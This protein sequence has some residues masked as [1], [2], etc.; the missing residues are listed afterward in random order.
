MLCKIV[1]VWCKT[2][3]LP[4]NICTAYTVPCCRIALF[5]IT[6]QTSVVDTTRAATACTASC[7]ANHDRCG[8]GD[9][10]S[11][12]SK[13]GPS[14]RQCNA[15]VGRPTKKE[16]LRADGLSAAKSVLS[17][18]CPRLCR[19]RC[20]GLHMGLD[21]Q[22]AKPAKAA[23]IAASVHSLR[24]RLRFDA[25]GSTLKDALVR[26]MARL[27]CTHAEWPPIEHFPWA[28]GGRPVCEWCFAAAAHMIMRPSQPGR[29]ELRLKA[30]MAAA[31]KLYKKPVGTEVKHVLSSLGVEGGESMVFASIAAD[32][33]KRISH[34]EEHAE[35]WLKAFSHEAAGNVQQRTDDEHDH[36]QGLTRHDIWLRY[37]AEHPSGAQ[38][39]TFYRALKAARADGLCDLSFHSWCAQAECACCTALKICKGRA[40]SDSEKDYWQ[41]QLDLHNFIARQERLCYGSNISLGRMLPFGL[42]C[43]SFALD[44]Y[45]T[46]KS[47]GPS[48]H[49]KPLCDLKG[50]PGLSGAEQLKFKTTGVIVHGFGYFLHV[51]EPHLPSNAN[52]NIYC[53][54]KTIMHMIGRCKDPSDD[55]VQMWP[56]MITVQVDGAS[57]NKCRAMFAYLEWLVLIGTFDCIHVS[58]LLVGHTHADYDQKF[59][60]LTRA[61]RLGEVK[62]MEDLLETFRC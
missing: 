10:G 57:D 30:S 19:V 52:S 24:E 7:N 34:K 2:V 51:L 22:A 33:T 21:E 49:A 23:A 9:T 31:K 37:H 17:F 3:P 55:R 6:P 20:E 15:H 35:C 8:A 14:S 28:V 56:R 53:L 13:Q 46:F 45:S 44:G 25:K 47:S 39:T 16:M 60:A 62:Q 48:L 42:A 26:E 40:Q 5:D 36:V 59:C 18:E 11:I 4:C 50:G 54:H 12:S 32:K 29:A 43:W 38:R 41:K 1:L 58:F 27:A 61:L